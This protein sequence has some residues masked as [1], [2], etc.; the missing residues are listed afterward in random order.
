[1]QRSPSCYTVPG[2]CSS[3]PIRTLT[4]TGVA[5]IAAS[6]AALFWIAATRKWERLP[7]TASICAALLLLSIQF[8]ALAGARPEPVEQM[9][10][11]V[12]A[13]RRA[14]EPVGTYQAF[15]R[16]LVF[17][18]RF[19][20]VDLYDEGVALNFLKSPDRVLLVTRASDLPR[21][22][23]I[24]GVSVRPIAQLQY[25]NAAGVRL[26]TVLSPIPE[27]DFETIVLVTNR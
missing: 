15:V 16:N 23:S 22:Q 25:L 27:Q 5:V 11:L 1:M 17:Y 7:A 19:K 4:L 9:A 10:A 24:A 8:G 13:N 20:Q 12:A 2:R 18:T 21:L 6:A 26:R 3:A 14:N